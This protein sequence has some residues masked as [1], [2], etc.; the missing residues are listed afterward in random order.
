M[1]LCQSGLL[2]IAIRHFNHK[3]IIKY[4]PN[5][6]GQF[7]SIE[8]MNETIIQNWNSVVKDEDIIYVLGDFFMGHI[9]T[10]EPIL[11]RLK[12]KIIL[13]RGNHDQK[14]RRR[15]FSEHGIEVKDIEYVEYKGK[16]FILNHFPIFNEEFAEM[17]NEDNE[18]VVFLYGHIHSKAPKGFVNGMYHVG[19]DTNNLTPISIEQIWQECSL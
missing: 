10:I 5:S 6:R 3:N 14:N 19:M 1:I 7:D 12:G 18:E 15:I 13:I 2:Q 17:V 4:E 11:N 9:S 8:E 16:F